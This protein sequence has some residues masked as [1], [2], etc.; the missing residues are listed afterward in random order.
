MQTEHGWQGIDRD[1]SAPTPE[2]VPQGVAVVRWP[3][4]DGR[5]EVV[6]YELVGD[7]DV[8]GGFPP[9]ELLELGGGR[10]VWVTL[11]G[12]ELPALDP[13]RTVLQIAPDTAPERAG[14]LARGGLRARARRLRGRLAAARALRDR[15][16]RGRPSATTRR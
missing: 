14:A 13:M 1:L 4:V 5:R 10:P 6:A 11:D 8:I 3:V 16:G 12:A 7:G 9:T 15:Q 2:P